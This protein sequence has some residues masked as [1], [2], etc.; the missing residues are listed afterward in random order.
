[1]VLTRSIV[2]STELEVVKTEDTM[3]EE[4]SRRYKGQN[5]SF[6]LYIQDFQEKFTSYYG[7]GPSIIP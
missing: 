5:E 6:V 4:A 7:R 2:S 3:I 1:M